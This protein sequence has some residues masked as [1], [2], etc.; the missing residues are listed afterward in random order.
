VGWDRG[1]GVGQYM[2]RYKN[3]L[4][5]FNRLYPV[6]INELIIVNH[7]R[8][9]RMGA[10]DFGNHLIYSLGESL[11]NFIGCYLRYYL[12]PSILQ[13]GGLD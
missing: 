3:F 12:T 7:R 5:F 13:N 4:L 8:S 11:K 10:W 2:Y 6:T 1:D 9:D